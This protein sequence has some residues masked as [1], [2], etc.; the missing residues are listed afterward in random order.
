MKTVPDTFSVSPGNRRPPKRLRRMT[1]SQ[2]HK[3]CL[4]KRGETTS[5][6]PAFPALIQSAITPTKFHLFS[7]RVLVRD[8]SALP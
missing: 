8:D 6:V 3:K 2:H 1:H 4:D 7:S 5:R